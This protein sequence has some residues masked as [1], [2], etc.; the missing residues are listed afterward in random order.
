MSVVHNNLQQVSRQKQTWFLRIS[1]GSVFGP[2]DTTTLCEWAAQSRIAPGNDISSDRQEWKPAE[3]MPELKMEWYADLPNGTKYGPFNVLAVPNLCTAGTIPS[4]AT[5]TNRSTGKRINVHDIFKATHLPD[6]PHHAT[7][8]KD[9][10]WQ[11]LCEEEKNLREHERTEYGKAITEITQKLLS[12]ETEL[13]NERRNVEAAHHELQ[14][15]ALESKAKEQRLKESLQKTKEDAEKIKRKSDATEAELASASQQARELS[16]Q[17]LT[18]EK[19]LRSEMNA[20]QHSLATIKADHEKETSRLK[21]DLA[22][23]AEKAD[24]DLKL[25]KEEHAAAIRQLRDSGTKTVESERSE[26]EKLAAELSTYRNKLIALQKSSENEASLHKK[27]LDDAHRELTDITGQFQKVCSELSASKEESDTI[28]RKA[29]EKESALIL[30]LERAS[31]EHDKLHKDIKELKN[32]ISEQARRINESQRINDELAA[33]FAE[34]QSHYTTQLNTLKQHKDELD[35]QSKKD[36]TALKQDL[37]KTRN[38]IVTMEKVA[39]SKEATANKEI[40]DIQAELKKA[41]SRTDQYSA[42]NEELRALLDNARLTL[43]EKETELDA[44]RKEAAS[45]KSLQVN[46]E[47]SISDKEASLTKELGVAKATVTRLEQELTK[48]KKNAEASAKEAQKHDEEVQRQ[49]DSLKKESHEVFTNLDKTRK[50]LMSQKEASARAEARAISLESQLTNLRN[51]AGQG[52]EMLMETQ[53]DLKETAE[54]LEKRTVALESEK[55]RSAELKTTLDKESSMFSMKTAEHE[56]ALASAKQKLQELQKDL[57]AKSLTVEQLSRSKESAETKTRETSDQLTKRIESASAEL[58]ETKKKLTEEQRARDMLLKQASDKETSLAKQLDDERKKLETQKASY[59]T[60]ISRLQDSIETTQRKLSAAEQEAREKG[61][62]A[63][64]TAERLKGEDTFKLELQAEK[65]KQD[66]FRKAVS[67]LES[68]L[69]VMRKN[70]EIAKQETL[71]HKDLLERKSLA[72][73][74]QEQRFAEAKE[75]LEKQAISLEQKI[76]IGENDADTL[77]RELAGVRTLLASAEKTKNRDV[78]GLKAD[79]QAAREAFAKSEQKAAERLKQLNALTEQSN[80]K[81][82]EASSR[83]RDMDQSLHDAITKNDALE[84]QIEHSTKRVEQAEEEKAGLMAELKAIAAA[85]NDIKTLH[86]STLKE[87]HEANLVKAEQEKNNLALSRNLESALEDARSARLET[88]QPS[89]PIDEIDRK[90]QLE[91]I[92]KELTNATTERKNAQASVH[93]LQKKLS[94]TITNRDNEKNAMTS[95]IGELQRKLEGAGLKAS[96]LVNG[97]ATPSIFAAIATAKGA[98][99]VIFIILAAAGPGYWIGSRDRQPAPAAP[100]AMIPVVHTPPPAIPS[101]SDIKTSRTRTTNDGKTFNIVFDFGLFNTYTNLAPEASALLVQIADKVKVFA[102]THLLYI[103]GHTDQLPVSS[104][105]AMNNYD[106]G[107]ARANAICDLFRANGLPPDF[108]RPIS[109]AEKNPPH[110]G[111]DVETQKKN[112]T[113]ILKLIPKET[114]GK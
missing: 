39:A 55:A 29:G 86:E 93:E 89:A 88:R 22:R 54:N 90:R 85:E 81:E 77:R 53:R 21:S 102:P 97:A 17:S 83:I 10:K 13:K 95:Q 1:D 113:V 98:L 87:L 78:V 48:S 57:S 52:T 26:A 59:E 105:S 70:I 75:N 40:S 66:S 37:E 27:T 5:L 100:Q 74:D 6:L 31:V 4:D 94:D 79:L 42:G 28:Q 47:K 114:L 106:L 25:L 82:Q 34:E 111:K 108:L 96:V 3:S 24:N 109:A 41:Q 99:V 8:S 14:M 92:Q 51:Q 20:L 19:E 58:A 2:V 11:K 69:A 9:D 104:K 46:L 61:V 103:E 84:R 60:S 76:K 56:A 68:E 12:T 7:D 45:Q 32:G 43:S 62:M 23:S 107:M 50:E 65:E 44:T 38:A 91:A 71:A 16:D 35:Q 36:I 80:L 18:A 72:M 101:P 110:P 73:Q 33:R 67:K 30:Q 49:I 112:R 15:A 63:A 64:Q